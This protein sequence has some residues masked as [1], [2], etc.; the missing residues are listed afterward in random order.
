MST[1]QCIHM[2]CILTIILFIHPCESINEWSLDS[3]PDQDIW[4]STSDFIP[5]QSMS[6]GTIRIG[7]IM[8]TEFDWKFWGRS[9]DPR[10][11][12]Y[13]ENFFRVGETAEN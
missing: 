3:Y 11:G 1:S 7:Q 6:Y 4:R 9:N 12:P 5:Q 2:W 13:Y 10:N 8:S